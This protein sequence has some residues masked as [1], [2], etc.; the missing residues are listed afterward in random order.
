M[1][2]GGVIDEGNFKEGFCFKV[3]V[4][5]DSKKTYVICAEE[6]AIK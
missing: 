5:L 3:N 4:V 6:L 1:K 2:K